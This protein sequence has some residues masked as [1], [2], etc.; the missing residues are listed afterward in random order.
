M[1][2][3][4]LRSISPKKHVDPSSSL[5]FQKRKESSMSSIVLGPPATRAADYPL[6]EKDKEE[7]ASGDLSRAAPDHAPIIVAADVAESMGPAAVVSSTATAEEAPVNEVARHQAEDD[8]EEVEE[9]SDVDIDVGL[10]MEALLGIADLT[11]SP[12]ARRVDARRAFGGGGTEAMDAVW[13]LADQGVDPLRI[14]AF[15]N[16]CRAAPA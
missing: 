13:S 14:V 1:A 2:D 5:F 6:L 3:T 7:T 10:A 12:L 11:G 16:A 8:L 4:S 9:V 15:I